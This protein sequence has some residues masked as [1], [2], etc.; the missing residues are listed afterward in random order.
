MRLTYFGHSAFLVEFNGKRLLFDPYI[1]ANELAKDIDIHSI[2]ADYVLLSHGHGDHVLD[3]ESIARSNQAPIVSSYEIVSWYEQKGLKGHPMNLGGSWVF[4]FGTVKYVPAV[5]SSVLPDGTYG[6]NPGGFVIWDENFCFYY[7]GDTAL[8]FDLQLL[9]RICPPIQL[10]ILPVGDN[11]TMGYAD[12]ILASDFI[13]CNQVLGVH[14]DTFGYIRLDHQEAIKA[15][16]DR[17]KELI[18]LPIGGSRE[19]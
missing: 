13:Q 3:A 16:K 8:T 18:L 19:W 4:P 10:A 2:K 14:Y 12:A 9:P 6:G 5:H 7:A 15:F 11:F 1:S 17:G